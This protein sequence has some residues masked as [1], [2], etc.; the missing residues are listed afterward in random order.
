MNRQVMLSYSRRDEAFV[1]KFHADLAAREVQT[2]VDWQDIRP[3]TPWREAIYN[4]VLQSD[5][6]LL[7]LS[8]AYVS[9]EMCRMECFLA[10]ANNK[11]MIP[12]M[13]ETCWED[14]PRYFETNGLDN[15]NTLLLIAPADAPADTPVY[16]NDTVATVVRLIRA[17]FAPPVEAPVYISYPAK[18]RSFT[19]QLVQD[20]QAAG[21]PVWADFMMDF[22]VDWR[23]ALWTVLKTARG[24]IVVLDTN[25][26][27]S[28]IIKKEILIARTRNLPTFPIVVAEIP[29]ASDVEREMRHAL[30]ESYEMRLLSEIQWLRPTPDYKTM[31]DR[32]VT[33]LRSL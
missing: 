15:L 30:D 7:F 3:G 6:M 21:I 11:Q 17:E 16:D 25:T 1:R 26:P 2:W 4:G 14:I 20:L 8:P 13:I 31:V 12:I 32:L 29:E 28:Q 22:G 24:M 5:A 27:G 9:S 33:S 23:D 10:R 18:Q 19:R